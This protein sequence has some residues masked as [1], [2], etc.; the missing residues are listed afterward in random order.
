MQ[1]L[2]YLEMA[3]FIALAL[4]IIFGSHFFVYYSLVSFFKVA[5]H[6]TK[7]W[8]GVILFALAIS[9]IISSIVAHYYNNI[10]SR[11]FYFLASLWLGV[12][13]N[14]FLA[15]A[16]GWGIY[17]VFGISGIKADL[18]I[19]TVAIIAAIIYSSYG[20]F[21]AYNTQVKHIT[22]KIKNLPPQWQGK[23]AVQLSDIHI[24]HVFDKYFLE[25]LVDMTNALHPDIVFITGDL[26]DG[27]DGALDSQVEPVNDIKAPLGTYFITGNHETYFGVDRVYD[28]LKKTKVKILDDR[29][30]D[31][32]GLQI[33]GLS[34][35][36]R[37]ATKNVSEAIRQT[38][39][40][41]NKP[42]ILLYHNPTHIE[43]IKSLGI[44]LQLSG[45]THK[46]QIFPFGLITSLI[47]RG[48]DYG[49]HEEGDYTEYTTNGAGA[50]GPTM[51]TGNTPEIVEITLESK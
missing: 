11:G 35:P 38:G 27:M 37:G 44:N 12:L 30:V 15:F 41:R 43:E 9:F 22:V 14:L 1:L 34:Y 49:L 48:Y 36:E 23:T 4:A 6:T 7:A 40:D 13:T 24:G 31:L 26:F 45:H 28:I 2:V 3:L 39:F 19:G 5:G 8:I 47:Y 50:W 32:N 25:K 51:R 33:V 46:G 18:A 20:V 16:L 10:F 29:M 21:N 17:W 42:S